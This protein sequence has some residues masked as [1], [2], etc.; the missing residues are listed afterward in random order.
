MA[1]SPVHRALFVLF[2]AAAIVAILLMFAQDQVTLKVRSDA[3]RQRAPASGIH[4][5]TGRE[6][7]DLRERLRRPD[8]WR[9]DLPADARGHPAGEA[10]HQHRNLHLRVRDRCRPVHRG[11][12]G[13]RA[14]RC[15]RQHGGRLGRRQRDEEGRCPATE[16]RRM[17][18]RAVQLAD[19]GTRSKRSTTAPTARSSSSMAKSDS[20]AASDSPTTGS[21]TRR[22]RSTGATPRSGCAGRS[23]RLLEA[24]FYENFIETAGEVTPELDDV[25]RRA[26]PGR[27]VDADPQL[28]DRRQQRPEAALP[29]G[30]RLRAPYP[31]HHDRRTSSSTSPATG[32]FRDAVARGVKVRILVEGDITDAMPVKYASRAGL[33]PP[34]GA[35][36]RDL[37]IPADDDAHQ[38]VGRRRHLEHVRVGELR[39]PLA[40][41]E[42]RAERRRLLAAPSLRAFSRTSTRTSGRRHASSCSSGGADRAREVARAVLVVLRGDILTALRHQLSAFSCLTMTT[43]LSKGR[44][45]Q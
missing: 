9:P 20:P 21:G 25:P 17:P 13:G 4:R 12:R 24:G 3:R 31:R 32:R 40:G 18:H 5:R 42:R 6:R 45:Q 23:S 29:A 37:R 11:A 41:V 28:A 1:R 34:A 43:T 10:A 35:R 38:D 14:S 33:R 2:I 15:P 16:E 27:R 19:A 7:L 36:H 26:A 30:D 22:T 8:Q 44:P 39:Q